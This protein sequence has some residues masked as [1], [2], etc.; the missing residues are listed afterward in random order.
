MSTPNSASPNVAG[1]AAFLPN[2][3]DAHDRAPEMELF[4]HGRKPRSNFRRPSSLGLAATPL[5]SKTETKGSFQPKAAGRSHIVAPL[6]D[7]LK[8]EGGFE[9]TT[10]SKGNYRNL[11]PARPVCNKIKDHLKPEEALLESVSE[12]K[13]AFVDFRP[14]RPM[15]YRLSDTLKGEEGRL[16]DVS[17]KKSA[18]VNFRPDRP[19]IYRLSDTLKPEGDFAKTSE[20]HNQFKDVH[21][22]RPHI[23]RLRDHSAEVQP[24][25]KME[26]STE[27]GAYKKISKGGEIVQP[28]WVSNFEKVTIS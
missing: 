23:H 1:S 18:F 26:S 12:K 25:G 2:D 22:Q 21:A 9:K 24:E 13:S 4:S 27:S 10:E 17:E 19:M 6:K 16:N 15:I 8:P 14:D 7:H 3:R 11:S 20:M 5:A 28:G